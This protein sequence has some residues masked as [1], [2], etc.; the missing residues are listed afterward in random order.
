MSSNQSTSLVYETDLQSAASGLGFDWDTVSAI[1]PGVPFYKWG[2]ELGT[3]PSLTY[4]FLSAP[5]FELDA[6]YTD[7]VGAQTAADYEQQSQEPGYELQSFSVEDR[8]VVVDALAAWSRS[9]EHTSELQ[10]T[11]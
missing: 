5:H 3:A 1:L 6:A 10:V 8:A 4:S 2:S 9:E 7:D 11:L